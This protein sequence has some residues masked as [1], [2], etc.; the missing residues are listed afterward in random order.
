MASGIPFSLTDSPNEGFNKTTSCRTWSPSVEG[1][2]FSTEV[3]LAA[4]ENAFMVGTGPE[5][6][7]R[8]ANLSDAATWAQPGSAATRHGRKSGKNLRRWA[9]QPPAQTRSES[10]GTRPGPV[11]IDPLLSL[12]SW[13]FRTALA[14][15]GLLA[16]GLRF[17]RFMAT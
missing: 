3:V 13:I 11:P 14:I 4:C 2:A 12:S 7:S 6:A 9:K 17:D 15:F 16:R 10:R 8:F 1:T 5:L